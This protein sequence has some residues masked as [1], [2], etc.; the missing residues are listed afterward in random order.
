MMP[1]DS[2]ASR[3]LTRQDWSLALVLVAL[4][5]L[6]GSWQ[7]IVGV[8]GVY[9]DDGIYVS[10]AKALAEGQGYR[11]INLPEAPAQTKY[12]PL[13]PALLAIIW[14]LYPTFPDNLVFMQFITLLSGAVMVGLAYLYLVRFGYFSRGVA[15]GAG[16]LTLSSKFYL[17]FCTLTLS[18][19]PFA[20]LAVVALWA[21]E[22]QDESLSLQPRAQFFLGVLLSLPLLTR[23]IGVMFIPFGFF[24][25]WKQGR[26][27]WWTALGV[28]ALLLPWLGWMLVMPQWLSAD[29]VNMYYTNYLAWW[30]SFVKTALGQII[31]TNIGMVA[32][33][34]LALGV[35][36]FEPGVTLPFWALPLPV[37]LGIITWFVVMQNLL[38]GRILPTY[39]AGYLLIVLVW[40]WLPSRFLVPILPFVLAYLLNWTRQVLQR[41]PLANPQWLASIALIAILA[42]NLAL[43]VR[44]TQLSRRGNF[45]LLFPMREAVAWQSYEDIFRWIN[46]HTKPSDV[47]AS[48]LDT[49]IFLYTG[50]QAFRPFQ[51]RPA[52]LFYGGKAPALGSWEEVLD[53]LERYKAR[54]LVQVP[55]PGFSEEKPFAVMLQQLVR[56]CPGLLKPVHVAPDSR[57]MIYEICRDKQVGCIQ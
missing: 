43:V 4:T 13:Y 39:L 56:R 29:S 34:T 32:L 24:R 30:Y 50:R 35:S 16:A 47:I 57:F 46:S 45:P 25:L 31:V 52:S 49:M 53:F 6:L 42:A 55:M 7:M 10:T 41:L 33:G 15:F 48:G 11:L 5:V 26:P 19:L 12:P 9:H 3:T 1:P 8:S 2:S 44:T 20:L 17:Y 14:K 38:K 21:L 27:L 51:G 54:F 22:R 37:L 28:S 23:I 18:E 36:L 40:P